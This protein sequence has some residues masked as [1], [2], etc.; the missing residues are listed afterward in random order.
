M[1]Y[2]VIGKSPSGKIVY[3]TGENGRLSGD[4]TTVE[5]VQIWANVAEED[6]VGPVCG[7]YTYKDHLSD[8]LSAIIMIGE[9]IEIVD[10]TGFP[11]SSARTG[12]RDHL[13]C[14]DDRGRKRMT[15]SALCRRRAL[16]FV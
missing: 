12:R 14:K 6:R 2:T 10:V 9:V 16:I 5:L 13:G 1:K 8:P 4:D 7:P 15:K 3:V 11:G